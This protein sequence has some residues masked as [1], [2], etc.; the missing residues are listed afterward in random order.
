M[1]G[2][3][4]YEQPRQEKSGCT[5]HRDN[6]YTTIQLYL[7]GRIFLHA[8]RAARGSWLF[9][10][11]RVCIRKGMV[12]SLACLGSRTAEP[13]NLMQQPRQKSMFS[14]FEKNKENRNIYVSYSSNLTIKNHTF[15]FSRNY[16]NYVLSINGVLLSLCI[17][18]TLGPQRLFVISRPVP[19]VP[20]TQNSTFFCEPQRD[21][22]TF[23]SQ[24]WRW[25]TATEKLCMV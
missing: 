7:N 12:V 19:P 23:L 11:G 1:P 17:S 5:V 3:L 21:H 15:G 24:N 8:D 18:Q 10:S 20:T 25:Q 13:T 2:S 16:W 22:C 6:E 9:F 14:S 4:T